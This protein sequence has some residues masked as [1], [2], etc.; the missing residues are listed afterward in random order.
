[1]VLGIVVECRANVRRTKHNTSGVF[2]L[3]YKIFG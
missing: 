1:Y 2:T 3:P